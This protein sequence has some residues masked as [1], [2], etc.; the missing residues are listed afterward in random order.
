MTWAWPYQ[1]RR[2]ARSAKS[3][4]GSLSISSAACCNRYRLNWRAEQFGVD[5]LDPPGQRRGVATESRGE[6]AR[7]KT[8]ADDGA[9]LADRRAEDAFDD[10]VYERVRH[11]E[12][13]A[14]AVIAPFVGDVQ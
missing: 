13:V 6:S 14:R 11:R 1:P 12:P 10:T 8:R 7:P 5:G 9:A 3:T 2:T 4:R